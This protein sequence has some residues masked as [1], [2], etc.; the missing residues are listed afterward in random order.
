MLRVIKEMMINLDMMAGD[1]ALRSEDI[2]WLIREE[3]P[4]DWQ[5]LVKARQTVGSV[6]VIYS[7]RRL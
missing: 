4:N 1:A 6:A 7:V 2:G 5:G 3:P